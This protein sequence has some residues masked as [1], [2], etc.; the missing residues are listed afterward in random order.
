MAE[1]EGG[2]FEWKEFKGEMSLPGDKNR[3]QVSIYLDVERQ[4]AKVRFQSPLG[5]STDWEATHVQTARRL[6]LHEVV[7]RTSG[8][9]KAGLELTW[10]LNITLNDE[11]LA[12]V[13]IARPNDLRIKGENGFTLTGPTSGRTGQ[14]NYLT[15]R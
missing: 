10:K 15:Q 6:K 11:T 5:G 9:P 12:G 3:H 2:D 13:V 14:D 8:L 4:S 7:F 1:Q